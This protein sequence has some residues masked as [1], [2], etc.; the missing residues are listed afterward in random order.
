MS[1]E[2]FAICY[3]EEKM[4]P[5]F[6]THYKNYFGAAI[7]IYDNNSTDKSKEIIEANGCKYIPYD[8]GGQ[9]RDDIYLD[10]KNN[11]W[12][13]SKADWVIV[14]DIDEFLEVDFDYSDST[15]LSVRGL[16]M[17]GFIDSNLGVPNKLYSKNIMFKPSEIKEINYL[18]GCHYSKPEGNIKFS[19]NVANLLHRKYIS[20]DY[21][22]ARHLMYQERL[23]DV[24]KK[25]G[26]GIEYQNVERK[27]IEDKFIELR[28][29]AIEVCR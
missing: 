22:L 18:A 5:H 14:C 9:I 24:N 29:N 23:S 3:N 8:S 19:R 26:W 21:V 2:V 25:F 12:K 6:I 10:I 13:N 4:L 11:C 20:E 7:T 16:D 27:K 17:V 1:V 28:K 15:I